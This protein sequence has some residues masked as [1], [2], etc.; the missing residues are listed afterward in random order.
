M[1]HRYKIQVVA[2]QLT[3]TIQWHG[4]IV[5]DH[6]HLVVSAWNIFF[7]RRHL[8]SIVCLMTGN[9]ANEIC[10]LEEFL[11]VVRRHRR[12]QTRNC[13][14]HLHKHRSRPYIGDSS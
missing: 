4:T 7:I 2:V 6:H 3:Q 1:S 9:N 13:T 8:V 5:V 14:M 10:G 11:S 12:D